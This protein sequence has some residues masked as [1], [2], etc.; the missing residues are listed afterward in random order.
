MLC[1]VVT[2]KAKVSSDD[3][4]HD[5]RYRAILLILW[6]APVTSS[7][8]RFGVTIP[9]NTGPEDLRSGFERSTAE[10]VSSFG[11]GRMLLEK[12]I[13]DGHHIEIQ[14]KTHF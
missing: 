8:F 1:G 11:D 6:S 14:V 10:A 2:R 7:G 13:Q 12:Y 4:N 3:R 9:C 5:N